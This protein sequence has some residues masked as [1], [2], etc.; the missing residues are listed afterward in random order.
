M[1]NMN[2]RCYCQI[3]SVFFVVL[4]LFPFSLQAGVKIVNVDFEGL[5][6]VTESRIRSRI[7]STEGSEYSSSKLGRDIKTLYRT[8]FFQNIEVEKKTIAGGIQLIFRVQESQKIGKLT[9]MGNKKIKEEELQEVLQIHE[10]DVLDPAKIAQTKKEILKL[11]EEKGY[12]LVDIDT[13]VEPYDEERNETEVILKIRE[14]KPVK[15]HRIRFVGNKAFADKKL[16]K[17]IKTKEKAMFSFMTGSG[18]YQDEKLEVDLQRLRFFYMDHGYLNIKVDEPS[19]TLTR[20]KKAIYISIPVQEGEQFRVGTVDVAGDILTTKPEIVEK[21]GLKTGEIYKKSLELQDIQFLEELYGDQAY[22]FANIVPSLDINNETRQASVTYFIQKGPKIKIDQIIVKGNEVT[23]DKVIRR[24]IKIVENS[25]FSKSAIDLSKKRLM[26]LGYFEDINISTPRSTENNKVNLVIDVKE[27]QNTGTFSIGAGFSTLEN[28][29]FTATIQKENFFGRGWSGGVSAN[30]SKLRQNFV[31]QMSDRYFLDT[32]WQFGV[33]LQKVNS[34]LN[35]FFDEN[36]LGGKVTFGRELFDFFT[37]LVGYQAEDASVS[38]FAV[39]V[40][41]FFRENASGFTSAVST[42]FIYDRRD[43]RIF[44]KKGFY[45]SVEAE[46]SE[47][48]LGATSEYYRVTT[49]QRA[50]IPLFKNITLKGRGSFAYINS[51]SSQSIGLFNRFFLGGVNTLRGFNL[52]SI[53]PRLKIPSGAT[54]ADMDFVYGGNKSLLFNAEL[55]IPIYAPA[56][57][58]L[59]GF[60]DAGD[61]Y[62][63]T[64]NISFEDFRMNYGVGFRWQSPL[65]PLRFEWGFPINKRSGESSAVFN[66]TIGQSF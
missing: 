9:V 58:Q 6:S 20:N 21:S 34:S 54:G 60:F 10:N 14:N 61:A 5:D 35:R 38:D 49:D 52:N 1:R 17:Q 45:S 11:Y 51:L 65:G 42:Q 7:S 18:K 66:F 28:F 2:R 53:G 62:G 27:R 64:E 47:S 13:V 8:G 29:I 12:Y 59:V 16:K 31:L 33:F 39:E 56:G 23:R 30:L 22:A 19:V 32:R 43:N 15:I 3:L 36:R 26:Q 44:T 4:F 55:E 41:A 48:R 46:Y 63:E 57:F 37:L 40:P 25:Y 50:F 24:E